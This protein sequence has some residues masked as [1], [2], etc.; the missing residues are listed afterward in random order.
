MLTFASLSR[1][2]SGGAFRTLL[3][4][5]F[6]TVALY[7]CP[8][9]TGTTPEPDENADVIYGGGATDEGLVAMQSAIEQ[10]GAGSDPAR[11]PVLDTPPQGEL[12]ASPIPEFSWHF[13][14]KAAQLNNTRRTPAPHG[15]PWF[16]PSAE[17]TSKTSFFAIESWTQLATK[18]LSLVGPPRAAMAHGDPMNGTGTLIVFSTKK[19]SKLV[20]VFTDQTSITLGDDAWDKLVNAN[21]EITVSLIAADFDQNR[22]AD[23]GAPVQGKASVFTIA[24]Q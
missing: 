9:E 22:I 17:T 15:V 4:V 8:N 7:G 20:R 24:K 23:G 5:P 18:S 19:D 1:A 14:E 11:N 2:K 21:A 13:G 12:P 10:E 6:A 16:S 3:F